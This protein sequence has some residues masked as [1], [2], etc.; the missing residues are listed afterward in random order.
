[1]NKTTILIIMMIL[2][3][4]GVEG[5]T[6]CKNGRHCPPNSTGEKVRQV[7]LK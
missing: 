4:A 6:V 5:K 2:V 1:M 7:V 3:A